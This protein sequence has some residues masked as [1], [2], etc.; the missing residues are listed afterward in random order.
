MAAVA[1]MLNTSSAQIEVPQTWPFRTSQLQAVLPNFV[2]GWSTWQY[3]V[4][5]ILGV[6][7][8][9]QGNQHPATGI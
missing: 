7:V 6:V 3:V 2:A 8:Y 5:F 9:D 4:T 1:A